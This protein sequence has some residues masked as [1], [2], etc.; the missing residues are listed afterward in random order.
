MATVHMI[1]GYL[2]AGKT[3]FARE[4]ERR[5]PALRLTQDEWMLRLYGEDPAEAEFEALA[6]AVS[7]RLEYVWT[8]CVSLGLD[9]V[10]DL[11]FWSRKQ[12]D[13]VR[14]LS[15]Q[16]RAEVR[17]YAL[18]C[19]DDVAWERIRRRNSELTDSLFIARATF[20]ALRSRFEPLAEDEARVDVP[21]GWAFGD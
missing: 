15:A 21:T 10:L 14:E 7:E 12:R 11:N 8:R 5:L 1:H 18:Q 13:R 20:E 16:L 3:T 19:D 2:G 9:V 6:G 4:L 17:L